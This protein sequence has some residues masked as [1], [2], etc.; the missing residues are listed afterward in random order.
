MIIVLNSSKT[1]DMRLPARIAKHSFPQF[2]AESQFLAKMLQSLSVTE[3]AALMGMSE[4]LAVLNAERYRSW[5][6]RPDPSNAKQALLAF[7]GDVF[8]AMNIGAYTMKEFNFAQQH[9]R[10][11]SGL[12]AV[13]RPL[14]LIQAYRLE[15][16]TRLATPGGKNLYA[17]WDN[18]I[19]DSLKNTLRKEKSGTLINLASLEYFKTV[20]ANQLAA[21]IITP[22][23]K[24]QRDS[25][26]RVV[27]IFAKKA[28]GR[29]CDFIIRNRIKLPEDLKAF[30]SD[31]YVFRLEL[32]TDTQWVFTRKT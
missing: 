23:F 30:N 19:H 8:E 28:R 16:G 13:L 32:S 9:L 10:I 18:R 20:K 17:F 24:E 5:K 22:V 7:K 29:M 31:G 11:L 26:F 3:M 6:E 1:L 15:M 14:D 21:R 4:K 25:S 27:A 2:S 12:Y